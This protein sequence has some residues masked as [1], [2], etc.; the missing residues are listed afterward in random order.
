ME[1]IWF[2]IKTY[3]KFENQFIKGSKFIMWKLMNKTKYLG[4]KIVFFSMV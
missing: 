1:V 3:I 4:V 2:L